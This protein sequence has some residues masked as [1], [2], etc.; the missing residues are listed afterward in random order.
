MGKVTRQTVNKVITISSNDLDDLDKKTS[1]LLDIID[2]F[3][4]ANPYPRFVITQAD[5]HATSNYYYSLTTKIYK[6]DV[7]DFDKEVEEWRGRE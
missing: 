7:E 1:E 5:V 2:S 6:Q 4:G 3:G